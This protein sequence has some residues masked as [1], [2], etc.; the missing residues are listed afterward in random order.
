[1]LEKRTVEISTGIIFRTV[2]ILLG[3]WFL[4]IVRDIIAILFI[5][6]IITSAIEPSVNRMNDKK[7]PRSL[8]VL[9]IYILLFSS[10][11]TIIYFLIPP[12][13]VQFIDF[14]QNFPAYIEKITSF[15]G[16]FENYAQSHSFIFS[17]QSFLQNIGNKL[18]QSSLTI[19]STTLGVFSGFVSIVVV[20]SL[21]FYLSAKKDG[22]KS[23]VTAVTPEKYQD[24]AIS[25]AEKIKIKIGRWVHGQLFLMLIIFIL[26]FL[27]LYFL[28]VPYALVLA[29]FGGL[30]EIIPYLGPI[31][32]AVPA[33]ILGFLVSPITG[34]MVIAVYIIIHQAES[35]IITPQ[36][37]KKAVGLNPIVVILALLI[38]AKIGGVLGAILA[39]PITT[40]V[41]VFVDDLVE[42]KEKK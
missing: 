5:A 10:I 36:I 23:F 38:G 40:A 37:M 25:A 1:M 6:V 14:S 31:I 34:L 3:L 13:V 12:L 20:I 7:I 8:A 17:G 21:T 32:S 18:S 16:G 11:G 41:S 2:L 26:D 4:Y 28:N 29:I 42:K 19:F 35:H 30:L 9:I 15:S 22:M 33:A 27:A 24:Y 39:V